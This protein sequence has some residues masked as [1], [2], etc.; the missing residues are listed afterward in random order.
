MC[1][2]ENDE[3]ICNFSLWIRGKV[4][5]QAKNIISYNDSLFCLDHFKF[6]SVPLKA[7]ILSFH[8]FFYACLCLKQGLLGWNRGN[9]CKAVIKHN[10]DNWR[11]DLVQDMLFTALRCTFSIWRCSAHTPGP[12]QSECLC[13]FSAYLSDNSRPPSREI[14]G[15][16]VT[17]LNMYDFKGA[18]FRVA[19]VR[20]SRNFSK[21]ERG[22]W[23]AR[24]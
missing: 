8:L 6:Q 13:T 14:G 20:S 3:C 1:T 19:L 10:E 2:L 15:G 22:I 17:Y 16:R 7:R 5:I 23:F 11:A 9:L 21:N 24:I 4:H 12:W 18:L